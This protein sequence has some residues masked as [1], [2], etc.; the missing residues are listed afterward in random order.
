MAGRLGEASGTNSGQV[1]HGTKPAL[2]TRAMNV[3]LKIP[4]VSSVKVLAASVQVI[5]QY[6]SC[7]LPNKQVR[8]NLYLRRVLIIR[9]NIY[10]Y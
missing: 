8:T 1:H 6:D 7:Q 5:T 10:T 9:S 4:R 2:A 3:L